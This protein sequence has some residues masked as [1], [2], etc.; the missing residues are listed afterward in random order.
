VVGLTEDLLAADDRIWR[1]IEHPDRLAF[2]DAARIA[3]DAE[4]SQRPVPGAWGAIER[5]RAA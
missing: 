1:L 5:A 4:R 2:A 3:L